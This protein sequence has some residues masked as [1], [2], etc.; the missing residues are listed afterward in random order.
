MVAGGVL[1]C[2]MKVY[3]MRLYV[4]VGSGLLNVF[5]L[6]SVRESRALVLCAD[7]DVL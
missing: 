7:R 3:L 1:L 4:G 2:G 6:N 5:G